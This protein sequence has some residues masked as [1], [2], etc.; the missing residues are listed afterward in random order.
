MCTVTARPPPGTGSADTVPPWASTTARTIESPSPEPG[1]SAV[2]STASA[3]ERLEELLHPLRS[4]LR[5][6]EL[7]RSSATGPRSPV[8]ISTQPAGTLC[9]TAF[10][11]RFP[12][13]R[14]SST[15]SP[16]VGAGARCS[17]DPQ[18]P[19]HRLGPRRGQ[20]GHDHV[21]KIHRADGGGVDGRGH[22]AAGQ[23]EQPGDQVVR[24]P[25]G[26]ADHLA[27]PPELGDVRV[28]VGEGHVDLGPQHRQRRAQLVAG[29]GDEAALRV[30]RRL[31]PVEHRVEARGQIGH[32]A[33][34][35]PQRQTGVE[36]LDRQAPRCRRDRV[37]RAQHPPDQPPR[38]DPRRE[39]D[40]REGDQPGAQHLRLHRVPDRRR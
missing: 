33:P 16:T 34:R 11:T 40:E 29:V 23:Q 3:P 27:H 39:H 18:P 20:G 7:T 15:G 37:Q 26:L 4:D 30:E 9:R 25:G 8:R 2:R 5:S 12:A 17:A 31:Q 21:G 36:R 14:S 13:T 22:L 6:P 35:V 19:A 32:L 1:V 28:R 24:P 38:H 10:S